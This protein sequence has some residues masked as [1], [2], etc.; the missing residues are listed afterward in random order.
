[1]QH[2]AS[3]ATIL[4]GPL[5]ALF[6]LAA[7]ISAQE[8]AVA[9][10]GIIPDGIDRYDFRRPNREG[11]GKFYLGREISHVM[12][13]QAAAWL[14]RADRKEQ[15]RTD[16]LLEN[17]PISRGDNVADIG[18]GTGYFSLPMAQMVGEAGT[19]YAVDIQQE[20]LDIIANRALYEGIAN[21]QPILAMEADPRLPGNSIDMALF[22]DAYHEFEW[23]WEVMSAVYE[24][25]VPGGKVVLIEYRAEDRN[26]PIRKLHK[27]TVRQARREMAAVGLVF[28]K[29]HK[30][31]PQQHFLVFEKPLDNAVVE[32]K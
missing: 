26:V 21:I 28:V 18:A 9:P 7:A 31:L 12:G 20:M 23:P 11:I 30:F 32:A 8:A 6:L 3:R 29:N 17:L 2:Q 24:S 10:D 19:V 4:Y 27:M 15:E 13:H 22:V 1:M 25:L 14:E 16:L 5:L